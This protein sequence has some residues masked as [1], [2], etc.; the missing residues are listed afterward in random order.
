MPTTLG[1]PY[2][3][4]YTGL[5]THMSTEDY[6]IW[7][8]YRDTHLAGALALYFDVKLGSGRRDQA[9][10]TPAEL[11]FWYNVNAKRAD[12]VARFSDHVQLIELRTN[13]QANA[14]GRLI[15]YRVLWQDDP[16]FPEPLTVELVTDSYDPDVERISQLNTITYTLLPP[17]QRL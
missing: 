16:P 9:T 4:A 1:P 15:T 7:L 3:P 10:G 8:R 2:P 6:T 5:P 13:A 12:V 14:V 11:N 17:Y